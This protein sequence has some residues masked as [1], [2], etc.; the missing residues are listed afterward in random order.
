MSDPGPKTPPPPDPDA[1]QRKKSEPAF[2]A[3]AL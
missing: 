3:K 2:G 1:K